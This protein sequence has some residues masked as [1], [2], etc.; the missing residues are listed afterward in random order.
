MKFKLDHV[1]LT[2]NDLEKSIQFYSQ[3]FG[4]ELVERGSKEDEHPWA[5][6]AHQDNMIC[7]T[8]YKERLPATKW[9]DVKDSEEMHRIYHF[10]LRVDNEEAWRDQAKKHNLKLYYG[11]VNEYP[12]SLSWYVT[13]PSGHMIEVSYSGGEALKF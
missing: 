4:F 11:G 1:N 3:V 6:V 5:I 12:H 2:V 8:E 13:D 10:G 9:S 7:M